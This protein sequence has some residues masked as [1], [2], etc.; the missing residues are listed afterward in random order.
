MWRRVV[1]SVVPDVSKVPGAPLPTSHHKRLASLLH[2]SA[3][4]A[5]GPFWITLIQHTTFFFL[6]TYILILSS[7]RRLGLR[8]WCASFQLSNDY[9]LGTTSC[10]LPIQR[11]LQLATWSSNTRKMRAAPHKCWPSLDCHWAAQLLPDGLISSCGDA[12]A[13]RAGSRHT[14]LLQVSGCPRCVAF[15]AISF[16]LAHARQVCPS[17]CLLIR[18]PFY[19]LGAGKWKTSSI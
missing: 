13:S 12:L 11:M 3:E 5:T 18:H 8:R 9:P 4:P 19:T 7:E 6:L 14:A 16:F 1:G 15:R 2:V 10:C 17:T